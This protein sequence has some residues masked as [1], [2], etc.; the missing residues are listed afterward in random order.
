MFTGILIATRY[1]KILEAA[2]VPSIQRHYRDG[3]RFKQDDDPKH[4][5]GGLGHILNNKASIGG[6]LL[7]LV[8][9]SIQ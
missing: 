6:L 9:T 7:Q 5:V 2:L 3:H 4:K 1:T 8:L